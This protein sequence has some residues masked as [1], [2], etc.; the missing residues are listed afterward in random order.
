M[1][2]EV[3]EFRSFD[4]LAF[5]NGAPS[6]AA[7]LKQD[8]DDFQVTEELGFPLS[9]DG[10][11]LCVQ[12][13]KTDL[14]TTALNRHLQDRLNLDAR[15]IGYAG[16]KDRRAVTSQWFSLKIPGADP[17]RDEK[18]LAD[19]ENDS[20]KVLDHQRNSRKIKIGS[21]RG[22]HFRIRLRNCNESE[23]V[24]IREKWEERLI[25]FSAEGLPNYF[26]PQRFGRDFS[27]LQQAWQLMNNAVGAAA[28]SASRANRRKKSGRNAML[29]SATRSY[30]FNLQLSHRLKLANWDQYLQGD[31]LN[32]D[33][34]NRCFL[35][36]QGQEWDDE[37]QQRLDSLD[38]HITG[39]L[40]G[41]IES[42]ERYISSGKSADI[43]DVVCK[44]YP[45]LLKGLEHY[46][47]KASRR[48]FRLLP[49]GLKWSWEAG[50]E[51]GA[52]SEGECKKADGDSTDLILE[53]TLP[54]GAYATSLLRELC[55]TNNN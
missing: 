50:P 53:F 45:L 27:N 52:E 34:S 7:T 2:E 5:A 12:I 42:K 17:F 37:L 8:C 3:A 39:L 10:E 15:A 49:Q 26:G 46:G 41:I 33:S 11:H 40:P 29:F 19:I 35:L 51:S 20:V 23:R 9:G 6:G 14:T 31:V 43:E 28:N 48:P 38:I 24:P 21:H 25:S 13:K 1:T 16:M 4:S 44:E 47:L 30:L 22:N 36:E 54:K 18:I 55:K 32:L